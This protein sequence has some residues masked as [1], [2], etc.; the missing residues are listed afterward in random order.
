MAC[1]NSADTLFL[2]VKV[3]PLNVIVASDSSDV[4]GN[5]IFVNVV[6]CS[7][8]T[9]CTGLLVTVAG[10]DSIACFQALLSQ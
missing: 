7:V 10:R 3:T 9:L 6:V 5:V 4:C 8:A 2:N 1:T